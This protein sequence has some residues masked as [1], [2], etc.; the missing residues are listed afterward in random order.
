MRLQR[1]QE[2]ETAFFSAPRESGEQAVALAVCG[3]KQKA[4]PQLA[5][6]AQC[7]AADFPDL[8]FAREIQEF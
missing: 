7:W 1:P 4:R 6:R 3:V 8:L 2:G 5:R